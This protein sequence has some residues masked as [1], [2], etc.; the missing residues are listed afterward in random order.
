M[1]I[2]RLSGA[3]L[4]VALPFAVTGVASAN[5]STTLSL[6]LAMPEGP[7]KTVELQCDPEGGTHPNPTEACAELLAVQGDFTA[8][9]A[10]QQLTNCTMEYRPVIAVADGTWNGEPVAWEH[11]FSNHCTMG[12]ATGTVFR[13]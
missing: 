2:T 8:L 9:P 11:E 12:S 6:T 4:A 10:N 5:T 3:L 7:A 13:F 1:N